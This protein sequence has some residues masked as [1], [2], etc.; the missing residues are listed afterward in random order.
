[1]PRSQQDQSTPSPIDRRT[2]LRLSALGLASTALGV[3]RSVSAQGACA[4]DTLDK[5]KRTGIFA[6]GARQSTPP[7]VYLDAQI[8]SAR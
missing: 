6:L 5:I 4:E 3:P 7:Y 2:A 1:M 8:Q